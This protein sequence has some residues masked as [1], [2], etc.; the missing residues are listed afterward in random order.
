MT[1]AKALEESRAMTAYN[2]YN[3]LINRADSATIQRG[4]SWYFR[5]FQFSHSL[6]L[7]YGVTENQSAGIIA[8][9]SPQTSFGSNLKAAEALLDGD[10]MALNFFHGLGANQDKARAILQGRS[11]LSILGGHKVRGFY[12]SILQEPGAIC[13]DRH[14]YKSCNQFGLS[15][16][17]PT[18]N[19][20]RAMKKAVRM[21]A[22]ERNWQTFQVQA[23]VW[24]TYRQELGHKA[25]RF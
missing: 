25:Y 7:E 12:R 22:T 3:G 10:E 16:P 21:I 5:A 14:M 11:P 13:I 24:C 18:G 2:V 9:L 23:V 1:N 19:A 20:V 6:S 8:A 4:L 15:S 17:S